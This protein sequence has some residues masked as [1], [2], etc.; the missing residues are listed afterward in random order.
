MVDE[1]IADKAL[2][3]L[4]VPAETLERLAEHDITTVGRLYSS[5]LCTTED[6]EAA[7][8]ESQ[9]AAD[10]I[11]ANALPPCPIEALERVL[12]CFGTFRRFRSTAAC[13]ILGTVVVGILSAVLAGNAM[14]AARAVLG[15]VAMALLAAIAGDVVLSRAAREAVIPFDAEFANGTLERLLGLLAL[16]GAG[17]EGGRLLRL[18]KAQGLSEI[19]RKYVAGVG[20]TSGAVGWAVVLF[21]VTLVLLSIALAIFVSA[22]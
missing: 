19:E 9:A 18:L 13:V 22:R 16:V 8:V 2:A 21:L 14:V 6:L 3:E 1:A 20:R 5:L 15:A 10:V 7:G 4:Q 17:Q 11:I 12:A